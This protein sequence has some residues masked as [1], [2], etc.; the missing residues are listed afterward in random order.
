MTTLNHAITTVKHAAE[1]QTCLT[2]EL[3]E[4][5]RVVCSNANYASTGEDEISSLKNLLHHAWIHGAY[6]ELG[7][8]KMDEK[9]R[10]L[11][12]ALKAEWS[13]DQENN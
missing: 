8:R 9:Q 5:M 11:M 2:H 6:P 12:D 13:L 4:A 10:N 3:R 1:T 7:Y